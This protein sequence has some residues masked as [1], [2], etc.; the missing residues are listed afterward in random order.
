[1]D[2]KPLFDKIKQK[3]IALAIVTLLVLV[4]LYALILGVKTL[5]GGDSN[6]NGVEISRADIN[7]FKNT[8][9]TETGN[10]QSKKRKAKRQKNLKESQI[11][12]AWD[13]QLDNARALLQIKDGTF[14][15]IIVER[16]TQGTRF[17]VN[18]TYSLEEDILIFEPD[19]RSKAP[20][21][22]YDYRILTRAKMP[23]LVGK[24]KGKMVWQVPPEEVDIYVPN[25]HAVLSRVPNKIAIWSTLK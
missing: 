13:A 14:R 16:D 25:Y 6:K 23:M 10:P 1:M 17:Y 11:T 3:P 2:V 7:A 12:G 4:L 21:D 15:L 8:N 22:K 20:S 19:T 18:G 9:I 24:Y 5:I